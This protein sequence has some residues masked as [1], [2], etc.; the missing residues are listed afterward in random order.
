M[1]ALRGTPA[2]R[3]IMRSNKE[4]ERFRAAQPA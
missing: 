2:A 4:M 1:I 3:S